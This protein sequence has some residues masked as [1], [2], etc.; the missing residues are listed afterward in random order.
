MHYPLNTPHEKRTIKEALFEGTHCLKLSNVP[1][2]RLEAEVLLG[3][4]LGLERLDLYKTPEARLS[5]AQVEKYALLLSK[6]AQGVP[7]AYL[8]KKKDFFSMAFDVGPGVLIPRAETEILV[9]ESLRLVEGKDAPCILEL[10]TGSGAIIIALLVHLLQASGKATETSKEALHYA[11]KNAKRHQVENRLA[12]LHGDLFTP[13]EM[14]APEKERF[15]LIVSNPPYIPTSKISE[16]LRFEPREAFDGGP[17]GFL[18]YRRIFQEAANFLKRHG[19]LVLEIGPTS[20]ETFNKLLE[21]HDNAY[22]QPSYKKDLAGFDRALIL[23]A[24]G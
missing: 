11:M 18:F 5:K 6:R 19:S 10:G 9:E 17:D 23:Q 16:E 14:K 7:S 12:L 2:P 15:D 1:S 22:L 3:H 4:L 20:R 24:K 8:R 13:I 21:N